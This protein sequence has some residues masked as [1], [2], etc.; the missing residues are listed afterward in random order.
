MD[1][2]LQHNNVYLIYAGGTFGSHGTPLSPLPASTFLPIL[3]Q[4]ANTHLTSSQ[5]IL[6]NTLIKDSSALTPSDFVHFYELILSAYQQGKRRF[7]L[8]TGTDT[9]SFLAAFLANAFS[10]YL[11]LSLV[12]TGSMQPL[13]M[14]DN[15][16]YHIN[17][18]SDAWQ[19]L[20]GAI[21]SSLTHQGVLVHFYQ[22][23]FWANNTQKIHS[24]HTNAFVGTSVTQPKPPSDLT[25]PSINKT[26]VHL[27]HIKTL[28]VLPNDPQHIAD[29]LQSIANS[30]A[31]AI[32]LVCFGAGN[33][34]KTDRMIKILNT[35]RQKGV[36]IVCTTM[37]SFGG[38]NSQYLAGSWQ[39]QHGVWSG[40]TLSIAGIYGKLLWLYLT[41]QLTPT[42]WEQ[43]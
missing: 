17:H 13:L 30:D 21:H 31:V 24:Q 3:Q 12:I 35:L 40:G 14:A 27:A 16:N 22:Q 19:N 28:Y 9:L 38:V 8:I 23:T 4:L 36:A 39:Y 34:S 41:N 33:L 20:S 29:E 42:S 37:C 7:V 15:P 25:N 43:N 18:H 32:I 2:I 5:H 11:E 26:N 6:S 1:S 10:G